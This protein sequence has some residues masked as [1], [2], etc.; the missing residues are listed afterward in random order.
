MV[1]C[2]A[3]KRVGGRRTVVEQEAIVFENVAR[4][5]FGFDIT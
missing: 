5:C 4:V 1:C 2:V 3:V